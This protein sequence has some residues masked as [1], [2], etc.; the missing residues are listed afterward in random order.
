MMNAQLAA[1]SRIASQVKKTELS[2]AAPDSFS[3][4]SM[5]DGA[6]IPGAVFGSSKDIKI[7]PGVSAIS[8]GVAEGMLLRR[9]EPVYPAFAKSAHVSGTVVLSGEITKTG[10]LAG[11]RVLSGPASLREAALDAVKN[12]RYR[13]YMLNSQPVE[14]QTTIRVIFSL[15]RR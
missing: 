1:P 2:E 4:N 14:V 10:T 15:E 6:G 8:A 9:T 11:L 12:W 3:P 5:D 13:P 7:V